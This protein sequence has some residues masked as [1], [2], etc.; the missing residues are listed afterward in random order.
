MRFPQPRYDDVHFS[1]RLF[2]GVPRS[3]AADHVQDAEAALRAGVHAVLAEDAGELPPDR[4]PDLGP[5]REPEGGRHHADHRERFAPGADGR[6]RSDD[7]GVSVEILLPGGVAQHQRARG[8]RFVFRRHE[9]PSVE[10]LR[11]QRVEERGG[12]GA[13]GQ[14]DRR[15]FLDLH[16]APGRRS[17]GG[18]I[19]E[20]VRLRPPVLEVGERHFDVRITRA[21]VPLPHD[22][23]LVLIR[24][25]QR[26]EEDRVDHGEQADRQPEAEGQRERRRQRETGLPAQAADGVTQVLAAR[27]G[28]THGVNAS[29]PRRKP[30]YRRAALHP[31]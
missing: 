25:G 1:P 9:G 15:I 13:D 19:R 8:L 23:Q 18:H 28:E 29:S 4:G 7:V 27:V 11:P 31:A 26:P 22:D 3:E 20:G 17:H 5:G 14:P 2:Q 21:V 12:D 30:R 6:R 16:I 24:K 10:R